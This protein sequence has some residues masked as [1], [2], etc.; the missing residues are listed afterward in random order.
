MD[1]AGAEIEHHAAAVSLKRRDLAPY[2]V[3]ALVVPGGELIGYVGMGG[4]Q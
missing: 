2:A 3:A 1:A 4:S